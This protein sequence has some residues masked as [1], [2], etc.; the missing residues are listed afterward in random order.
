MTSTEDNAHDPTRQELLSFHVGAQEYSIDIISV[1]EIR[2]WTEA[3]PL[4]HAP[5]Y[6]R[7]VINLRGTVLPIIDL[8]KRLGIPAGEKND[9]NVIV[10]VQSGD[11]TVGLLVDAVS[12]IFAV[13]E[14]EL[15]APPDMSSDGSLKCV[16]ALTI[17]EERM[18]RVLDLAAV[19]PNVDAEAA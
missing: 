14:A 2:S 18:L 4:P 11:N 9:R 5:P 10:V 1:R 16:R 13:S 19:L 8:A 7:G 15:Q 12:D 6:V 3:T 17:H